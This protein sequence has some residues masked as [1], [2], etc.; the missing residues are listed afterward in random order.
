MHVIDELKIYIKPMRWILDRFCNI[1]MIE[2]NYK[3][4]H[5]FKDDGNTHFGLVADE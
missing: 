2:Y 3:N 4:T 1:Q 5:V